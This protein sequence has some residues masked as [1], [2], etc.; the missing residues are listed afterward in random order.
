MITDINIIERIPTGIER[1]TKQDDF[2]MTRKAIETINQIKETNDVPEEYYLRLGTRSGG[3][4]GMNYMLGFDSEVNESDRIIEA[5]G[6]K[7]VV[8]DQ[9]LF[10]LQGVTLDYTDGA[11]GAGFVFNNPNDSHVCGCGGGG[12]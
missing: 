12:H 9:S 3:C 11:Q 10:Y 1:A 8:D 4:S 5:N 6:I 2:M 7:M